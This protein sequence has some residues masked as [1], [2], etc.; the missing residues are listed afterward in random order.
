MPL[1]SELAVNRLKLSNTAGATKF[2]SGPSS[3]ALF[4]P[5]LKTSFTLRNLF[6][7]CPWSTG[8]VTGAFSEYVQVLDRNDL[9][10]SQLQNFI[11]NGNEYSGFAILYTPTQGDGII[12]AVTGNPVYDVVVFLD[13]NFAS[14]IGNVPIPDRGLIGSKSCYTVSVQTEFPNVEVTLANGNRARNVSP[15]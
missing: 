3:L 15:Y 13:G 9:N 1:S 12:D 5:K 4:N 6:G 14:D 11:F 8:A 2:E 7:D 10:N